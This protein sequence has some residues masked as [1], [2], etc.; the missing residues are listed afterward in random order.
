V[1]FSISKAT[2]AF[3]QRQDIESDNA[4][5]LAFALE[6]ESLK[7]AKAVVKVDQVALLW[8]PSDNSGMCY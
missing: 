6:T 5:I 2:S 4:K 7:P 3:K 1:A 8:L